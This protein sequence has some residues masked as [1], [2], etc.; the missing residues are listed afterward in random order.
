ML[1][2]SRPRNILRSVMMPTPAR[3]VWRIQ[4]GLGIVLAVVGRLSAESSSLVEWHRTT[5]L[6]TLTGW[7]QFVTRGTP[8]S[9]GEGFLAVA[10]A[11]G[12]I[13]VCVRPRRALPRLALLTGLGVFGFYATWGLAYRYPSLTTRLAGTTA[14]APNDPEASRQLVA[15]TE[16]AALLVKRALEAD[17][18]FSDD[19]E[20]LLDRIDRGLE[21]GYRR[22]PVS[23]AAAPL[24]NIAFGPVKASRV[25][26]AMSRLGIS[27]Y[28]FPWT[29]EAQIN[30]EMARTQWPRVAGHE[31][32][33]QRG[34]ARENEASVIGVLLCLSSSEPA[35]FYSG[36][37]GLFAALDRE[38]ARVDREARRRI[39]ATLPDRA[40][41]D[42]R[43]EALFWKAHEGAAAEVGQKVND[44][45]LKAQGVH[46]GVAS[47][48]ETTRLFLQAIETPSLVLGDLLQEPRKSRNP[49]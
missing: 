18:D 34:F 45:Y 48:G 35:V 17:P 47:Y 15:L 27:G 44:T 13:E 49:E 23:I 40:V 32:A 20:L 42:F 7:L 24:G 10:I 29:G 22:M 25:S 26:F 43:A 8:A 37:M 6:P 41:R 9:V 1:T 16:R 14:V 33:H 4:I 5:I 31:K 28:Y 2:K 30:R 21:G 12:L 3:A 38:V 19:S 11:L 39:W 46:S 36:A